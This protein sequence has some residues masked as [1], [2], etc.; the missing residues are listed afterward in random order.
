MKIPGKSQCCRHSV[1]NCLYYS[2]DVSVGE[3]VLTV[4]YPPAEQTLDEKQ[5]GPREGPAR[6][7]S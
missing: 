3:D 5:D 7:E 6:S 4:G 1:T 2:K